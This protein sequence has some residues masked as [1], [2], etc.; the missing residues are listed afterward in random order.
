MI[1]PMHGA[2]GN[3]A[4]PPSPPTGPCWPIAMDDDGPE[5]VSVTIGAARWR[6]VLDDAPALCR[7]AVRAALDRATPVPSL[8]TAEVGVLLGDDR[9]IRQLNARHRDIDRATNVLAF[10][11]LDLDH[12]RPACGVAP[13]LPGRVLLGDIAL[14][15]ETVCREAGRPASRSATICA[16][17]WC[18]ARCTCWAS[19]TRTTPARASWRIWSARS[20][21]I[22]SCPI[23]MPQILTTRTSPPVARRPARPGGGLM[24]ELPAGGRDAN[25]SLLHGLLTR[26]RLLAGRR[27]GDGH[28]L[29]ETLEELI[30]ENEEERETVRRV[31]RGGA[32]AAPQRAELRRAAGAR[33]HGAARR[34][35]GDRGRRRHR[36]R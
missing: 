26:L 3:A 11:L 22:C 14:A 8:A 29:R 36:A 13:G 12:G 7:Q 5:P 35:Q 30:E 33:R 28:T 32:L 6:A 31:H 16:I 23:P 4:R 34:R 9:A 20:W 21:P 10:P 24:K 1:E 25:A 15:L 27:N 17:W 19:I 2:A 18:T